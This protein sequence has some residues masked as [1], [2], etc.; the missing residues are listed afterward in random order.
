MT[1]QGKREKTMKWNLLIATMAA[2]GLLTAL[3]GCETANDHHAT[4]RAPQSPVEINSAENEAR[5]V[6]G[7]FTLVEVDTP[8]KAGG[9][10][11]VT[12]AIDSMLGRQPPTASAITPAITPTLHPG[13]QLQP[14]TAP[15]TEPATAP[16]TA[17][18][19]R[20]QRGSG[21]STTPP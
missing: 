12:T 13:V 19:T 6:S 9:P 18:A 5:V 17:P 2:G 20:V 1:R 16:A 14:T 8:N 4:N 15:A 11:T 10:V 21:D 3:P 7:A